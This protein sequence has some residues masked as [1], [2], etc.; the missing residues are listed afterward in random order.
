MTDV[1]VA[2][3]IEATG[4]DPGR[5]EII[6][7][8]AVKFR[9][10]RVIDR[11][12][13]LVRPSGPVSLSIQSLTGLT[14]DDLRRAPLFPLVA[15]RLRDFVG[16]APIVG[17][18]VGMDL[19]MLA[20]SGLQFTNTRYDT[21]E[22]AT[23]LLPEL[24]AYN[25]A[26]VAA[27][28]GVDVPSKHRA[29][30]DAETTMAVFNR[31]VERADLFD[32]A[33]LERLVSV[34][35]SAGTHIG[36]FFRSILRERRQEA[37]ALGGSS[38]GAQLI[39]QLSGA[40]TAG[41]EAMF[42]LP[43][44]RPERLEPTGSEAPI[45]IGALDVA[46]ASDGPLARTIQ[47]Y[48]VRPQQIEM[49]KAVASNLNQGGSLLV[50]AGTGTGK[51]LGYLLPAALHAVEQ[52]DRVVVSTATIALQDQ[53]M[54]KDL[55]ALLAAA[56]AAGPEDDE[57]RKLRSLRVA[58]LK[59]RANYLCL[60]RWF[61]A[62]REEP[63]AEPQAQLY[64]KIIA[65]LQQTETGDSAELHLS[66]DQR[67]YWSRLAEE[68]GACI[69]GQCVFH[70]RNQCFLFRARQEAEAAHV[71]VVNHSLLLSDMQARHTVI[72]P[73]RHL[74]VDEAHHLE[75][76]A[77]DQVGYSL[78]RANAL[79]LV[80]RVVTESEPLGIAG[81]LGLAFR[82]IAASP[83]ERA[84]AQAGPLQEQLTAGLAAAKECVARIDS[85]YLALGDFM[86]RYE[87]EA[88]G[89]DRQTRITSAARRDPGWSQLE[90][91]WD[92]LSQPLGRLFD[93]MRHFDQALDHFSDEDMPTRPEIRTEL[94]LLEQELELF[95][96]RMA[97]FVSTPSSETIYWLSRRPTTDETTGHTAPLHVGEILND[98]L[99]HRCDSVTLTSATLTADGSFDY[100][101]DR[102][103]LDH[104]DEL[105][106]PSPFDYERSVL[107]ALVDDV[108]E[109]GEAGHQKRLHEA[110]V[111]LCLASQ[112]RA[113][114]LF[115]SHSALQAT[116]RAVKRP[117]EAQ[118][119]LVLGQ[120]I[121]GS[122]RQLIERLRANPRTVL[123]GTNSFWEGVDIVG[124][125]LSLLIISKL[126]FPVPS[127]PVFAARSELF[128][129]P[130]GHY[131]V[132]QSILR[133][134]Q[135]FGR[136]I[137]SADDRGVCAVLDRRIITRRYGDAFVNSLP[138]CRVE[139]GSAADVA[140]NISTFLDGLNAETQ[141]A[142]SF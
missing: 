66:P 55:P 67:P 44:E 45:P 48:E 74:V 111:Q 103:A 70:R 126:P 127:D 53:L 17:Q 43:R 84:R 63:V 141:G 88:T 26:T 32:D 18:S 58:V 41:S 76:E 87:H 117:L 108:P 107:L 95:R 29:V 47:G 85:F 121:D 21:F 131:A 137:R 110:V 11:F 89:Y 101:R 20:A 49:M 128:D 97:E 50:E 106:V 69:P 35:V 13:T 3:D 73:F 104:A 6:E 12:E 19:D 96:M 138:D 25:L 38:I 4:M 31:L 62:Q 136:L 100:I 122:P 130:F 33:T 10:A 124:G 75:A 65:W 114:V 120:R 46:M 86:E 115:T 71:V 72:P 113:M 34:T 54:K 98:R 36:R 30:A 105:R 39:A 37:E 93:A 119:I 68:E 123:L 80:Q 92:D 139:R 7:I 2:L 15:P 24:P 77:T 64:A 60:R 102:L 5:D 22:L 40:G 79:D 82:S 99:F 52:G 94:E 125:A 42:L 83:L 112:G 118:N 90:I 16:L 134:K 61:L 142:F 27:A 1:C 81:T 78:S 51:S 133:F 8:G 91:E 135:G 129:D 9:G 14:N 140:D 132:P 28:L 109:P 57:L 59:G 23:V 56:E 116:Y